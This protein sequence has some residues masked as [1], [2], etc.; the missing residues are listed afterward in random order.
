MKAQLRRQRWS[1]SVPDLT[2]LRCKSGAACARL[3]RFS[4]QLPAHPASAGIRLFLFDVALT[5]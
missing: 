2:V 1:Q 4:A 5:S 3:N